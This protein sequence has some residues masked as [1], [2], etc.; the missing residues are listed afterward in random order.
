M[1]FARTSGSRGGS[2]RVTPSGASSSVVAVFG[3]CLAA[4]L[5]RLV[6]VT[7][8]Q[9]NIDQSWVDLIV[10]AVVL[11]AVLVGAVRQKQQRTRSGT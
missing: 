5:V 1:P 4:A 6:D 9:F 8:A 11:G 10:G 2:I 3:T 7:Q